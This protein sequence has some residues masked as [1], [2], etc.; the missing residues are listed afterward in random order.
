MSS[1]STNQTFTVKPNFISK[2]DADKVIYPDS[3]GEPMG[4]TD[5]HARLIL[6]LLGQ[7][8]NYLQNFEDDYV[9]GDVLFY[10]V[11]GDPKKYIVPDLMVIRG[12]GKKTR[13]VYKLWEEK[14]IPEVVFEI[15]SKGTWSEDLQ[16]K[17]FLYENLGV[18]EY[19]IF[20]PQYKYLELNLK[21]LV[22]EKVISTFLLEY[23]PDE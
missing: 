23:I 18:K 5:L 14:G 12:I 7:L 19:Y 6:S 2:N 10:Y 22:P 4:E 20:D 13:G 1:I 15:S 3:D 8:D 21:E 16:K 11:E 9:M 17:F